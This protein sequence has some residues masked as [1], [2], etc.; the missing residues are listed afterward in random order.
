MADTLRASAAGLMLIDQARKR[1]GWTKT[2]TLAWWQTAMTSRATLKRFWQQK[3]VQKETFI[4]I[5]EAVGLTDW[6]AVADFSEPPLPLESERP[7][8]DWG[9][10][11]D[12]SGFYGRTAE[13]AQIQAWM[14]QGNCSVLSLTGNSG[15]GKTHL[16]AVLVDGLQDRFEYVIWR[17][18]RQAPDLPTLVKNLPEFFPRAH[19]S[20]ID[21]MT[22]L[23]QV[24]YS[25]RCLLVLDQAEV[26]LQE[27]INHYREGYEAYGDL[28]WQMGARRHNSCL[29]VLS[30]EPLPEIAQLERETRFVKSLRL[31]DLSED[32]VHALLQAK[33]LSGQESWETLRQQY[34]GNPQVL[35]LIAATIKEVF[36]GNV[37]TFLRDCGT[38]VIPEPIKDALNR[39]MGRLCAE[40]LRTLVTL[41]RVTEPLSFSEI[42]TQTAIAKAD[43]PRILE[44]LKRRSLIETL[45]E[46]SSD[47]HEVLFLLPL[48]IKKY[49]ERNGVAQQD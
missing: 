23:M 38:L 35:T 46:E 33:A 24:F 7:T 22:A 42:Q 45:I 44:T 8:Q 48:V 2:V 4:S 1:K 29:L 26:V 49:L 41:A 21:P 6:Q 39:Q 30:Q 27:K 13:L 18:L 10:A 17:S 16:A 36:G 11:P 43:L 14:V 12:V 3:P 15:I 32:A 31:S 28:L 20:S 40:E 19:D 25:A 37:T 34:G 9:E 47:G 5:C